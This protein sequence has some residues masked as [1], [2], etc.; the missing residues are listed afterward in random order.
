MDQESVKQKMSLLMAQ[1]AC[2]SG[3]MAGLCCKRGEAKE[4][5]NEAC[6]CGSGK[7]VKDCCM[8]DPEAHKDI[9]S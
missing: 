7:V 3:K 9:V 2:G 8:Q 5:E 4:V 1:C 6:P